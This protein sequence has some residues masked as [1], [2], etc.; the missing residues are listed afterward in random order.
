ME[1]VISIGV[2]V[3]LIELYAWLPAI[4]NWLLERAVRRL[5][6][7]VQEHWRED[8]RANL[9]T[10]PNTLVKLLHAVSYVH[11]ASTINA[12]FAD[13]LFDEFSQSLDAV[14]VLIGEMIAN[15]HAVAEELLI[16]N[17]RCGLIHESI[18]QRVG[19]SPTEGSIR[20][21]D[22][23][24]R[25]QELVSARIAKIQARVEHVS[26]AA[27]TASRS[28]A[29]LVAYWRKCSRSADNV[30][31]V[32]K[33]VMRNLNIIEAALQQEANGDTEREDEVALQELNRIIE[34]TR[35]ATPQTRFSRAPHGV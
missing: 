34:A 17:A 24:N 35:S 4:T 19:A 23:A 28:H 31:K 29:E 25:A 32:R 3:V 8:W 27:K 21:L 22:A 9:D 2:G 14:D 6:P 16:L 5:R 26:G 20:V 15:Q 12:D 11:G 7:E 33:G 13:A 18:K 10:F 1:L 30:S